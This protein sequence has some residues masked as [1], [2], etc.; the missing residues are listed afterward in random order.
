MWYLLW[1]EG[2][3]FF[4]EKEGEN[5]LLALKDVLY[6]ELSDK[7]LAAKAEEVFPGCDGKKVVKKWN[8]IHWK[9]HIDDGYCSYDENGMWG[10][11]GGTVFICLRGSTAE[12]VIKQGSETR[13]EWV[14]L[15]KKDHKTFGHLS[16]K[17]PMSEIHR[18][19]HC[20]TQETGKPLEYTQ[21]ITYRVR[22]GGKMCHGA[23]WGKEKECDSVPDEDLRAAMKYYYGDNIEQCDKY[24]PPKEWMVHPDWYQE[25][26]KRSKP[27]N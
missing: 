15:K 20:I 3:F 7:E 19:V 17:L 5:R 25:P 26:A 9:C 6:L 24:L 18:L 8:D 23:W 2:P 22:I 21:E 13:S 14:K 1:D 12:E 16:D 4:E 27:N 11:A 10:S